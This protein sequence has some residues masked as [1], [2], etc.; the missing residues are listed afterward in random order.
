MKTHEIISV[1][2]EAAD[3]LENV[4]EMLGYLDDNDLDA[5]KVTLMIG[6]AARLVRELSSHAGSDLFDEEISELLLRFYWHRYTAVYEDMEEEF[7]SQDIRCRCI[8]D[9]EADAK[10]IARAVRNIYLDM[11]K[12]MERF[13]LAPYSP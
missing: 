2:T 9:M 13:D 7:C 5:I 6:P 11:Q 1:L 12:A 4:F 8:A 10:K 3:N